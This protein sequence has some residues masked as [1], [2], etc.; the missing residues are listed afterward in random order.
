MALPAAVNPV[1]TADCLI[2][3]ARRGWAPRIGCSGPAAEGRVYNLTMM[4]TPDGRWVLPASPEFF[5][6]LGDPNP[7]YDSQSFAIRNLGF[8]KF[9]I[10]DRL[11]TEIELHP[12]NVS[13]PA[14]LAV[15][16]KLLS[17]PIKLFRI[18]YLDTEWHSEISSSAEHTVA[19]LDELCAPQ[20]TPQPSERFTAVPLPVEKLARDRES[21]LFPLVQ[22]WRVS[23]GKFDPAVVGLASRHDLLSLM[24][25]VGIAPRDGTPVWR[26]IG[27]GHR[28]AGSRYQIAGLRDKVENMPDR[29]YGH[30]VAEFHRAVATSHQPRYD[31]VTAAMRMADE[32]GGAPQTV[33]YERLLLPWRTP[34]G[35]VF[36]T[37]WAK[38]VATPAAANLAPEASDSSVAKNPSRSSYTSSREV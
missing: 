13:R 1:F 6:A 33:R 24:V 3:G 34:S 20:F 32:A 30:W 38:K 7:D 35:E 9:E 36:I 16:D 18:K 28:W 19:R 11:V 31:A 5:A 21:D 17:S 37:S 14:L 2:S 26:Y 27:D 4:V 25:I 23:F 10:L 15:Q 8:V 29:E 12:R 22:K